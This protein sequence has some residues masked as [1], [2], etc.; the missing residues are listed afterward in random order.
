MTSLTLLV[1]E[2]GDLER[3]AVADAWE[4]RGGTVLR[5]GRFWD[6]P[7]VDA[8]RVRVYG[9]DTFC[10]VLQQKL[11]LDLVSPADDLI[12]TVPSRLT[13]RT[14]AAST[15]GAAAGLAFPTFVKP[16]TPKLFRAA[17]YAS[18]DELQGECV[19]LAADTALLVST[20]VT[21]AAEARCFVLDGRVLDCA[22]YEGQGDATAAAAAAGEIVAAISGPR[23][24]VLDL[25]LVAEEGR[26]G[27]AVVEFNA[28]W[29]A[30][31]NGCSA[32]RVLPAIE[33]AS[34]PAA[35]TTP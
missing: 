14:L 18:V 25:G 6:P 4:R 5:V 9:N 11:G 7:A 33:N 3:D 26:E 10:L 32:E 24:F 28:T 35:P 23:A 29:G 17:V 13:R 1:P 15:L 19:G 20:V 2:K 34:G 31:L 16:M 12:L 21:F 30:G 8:S 22:I 27:W